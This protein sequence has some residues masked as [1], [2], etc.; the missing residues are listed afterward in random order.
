[1]IPTPLLFEIANPIINYA[2]GISSFLQNNC[3]D[4]TYKLNCFRSEFS[5]NPSSYI[6]Q[7]PSAI[8]EILKIDTAI[9]KFL[10][11]IFRVENVSV[12]P[13]E[14]TGNET[15]KGYV[16]QTFVKAYT[17]DIFADVLTDLER[18]LEINISLYSSA[19]P[20]CPKTNEE[21]IL[22][23]TNFLVEKKEANA[24]LAP[25]RLRPH[26]WVF[27]FW[28]L[29][30]LGMLFCASTIVFIFVKI[31]KRDILEG[32]PMLTILMLVSTMFIYFAVLPFTFEG[33]ESTRRSICLARGLSITLSYAATFSLL[34]GRCILLGSV[35]KEV[36]FMSHIAGSVQS[37]MSLFIF[38]VQC[39]LS[40]H[41]F[42]N[43]EELFRGSSFI[44]ML[45]YDAILLALII[46]FCPLVAKSRR[47]YKEG[48]YFTIASLM[49]GGC[50]SCWIPAYVLLGEE[51]RD[52]V[53]CFGLVATAS[54]FLSVLFIPR[55]YLMT[56]AETRDK[57]TS[58]LP[59]LATVTSAI[60]LYR[61]STQVS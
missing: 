45:S 4:T 22:E 40:I 44:Y 14:G 53:L 56:I 32:N 57:L 20:M 34:L 37:F 25:L 49:T 43:C 9:H 19:S 31:C 38:G 50:W 23:C 39:A 54:I 12:Q 13:N 35:S 52:P 46:C 26:P 41:V 47:N 33:D 60:D 6:H 5:K 51:W 59:S 24:T 7:D 55:T 42:E 61:A 10:Y 16:V 11:N 27:G 2:S 28:V 21:C 48:K 15:G 8:A 29:S 30:F 1:M 58:A 17:Y 18:N 3:S 36:G